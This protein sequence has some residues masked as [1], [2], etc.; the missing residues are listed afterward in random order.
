MLFLLLIF[1]S[2]SINRLPL[3]EHLLFQLLIMSGNNNYYINWHIV[4]LGSLN[5]VVAL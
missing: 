3:L 5:V 4:S 2:F 1:S